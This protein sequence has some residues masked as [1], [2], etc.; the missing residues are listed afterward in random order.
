MYDGVKFELLAY[1]FDYK[2]L[3]EWI[4]NKYETKKPNLN[5]EFK[6]MMNSCKKN[7]VK[8]GNIEF[9]KDVEWPIDVIYPEIK[10]YDENKKYFSSEEWS[11]IDKF[12][13]SCV[14]DKNFPVFLDCSIHYPNA[15]EVANAI[16]RCRRK[17]FCCPC[18]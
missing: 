16:K 17:D 5:E 7:N 14:T 8:V 13:N 11:D 10:K 18:F 15:T 3:D 12:F 9:N 2:K 4:Y 6:Y 1:D